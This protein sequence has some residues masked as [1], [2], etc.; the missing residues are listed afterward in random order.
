MALAT[1]GTS[2]FMTG[3]FEGTIA[4]GTTTLTTGASGGRNMFLCKLTDA[5]AT[6]S[7]A[8]VQSATAMGVGAM[9]LLGTKV[10]VAGNFYDTVAFGNLNITTPTNTPAAFLASLTDATLTATTAS[11]GNLSFTLAPN[12]AR[13]STTVTLPALPCPAPPRPRSACSMPWA[14]PCARPWWPCRPP[15]CATN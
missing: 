11:Q 3:T 7:F 5:G 1:N 4:F 2:V 9:L 15:A 10:Y 6:S 8:W 13:T 12:P 14:G